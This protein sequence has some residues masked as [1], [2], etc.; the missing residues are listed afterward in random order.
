MFKVEVLIDAYYTIENYG[1]NT[2]HKI[3]ERHGQA[4]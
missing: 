3:F 4:D 1:S 2:H